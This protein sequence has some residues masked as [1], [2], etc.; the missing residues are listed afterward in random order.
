LAGARVCDPLSPSTSF[1]GF[2]AS[3]PEMVCSDSSPLGTSL[4]PEVECTDPGSSA[5]ILGSLYLMPGKSTAPGRDSLLME[6]ESPFFKPASICIAR[7]CDDRVRK[8]RGG[9]GAGRDGE[10]ER[11]EQG[12]RE[13]D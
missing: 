6:M 3:G 13:R 1:I 11:E 9:R 7:A 2:T 10:S 8:E 4:V 12:D 5:G